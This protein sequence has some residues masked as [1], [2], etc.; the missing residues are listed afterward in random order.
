MKYRP[1]IYTWRGFLLYLVAPLLCK[2]WHSDNMRY[3][4]TQLE[5][6]LVVLIAENIVA[7]EYLLVLRESEQ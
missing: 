1:W 7:Q 6:R 3:L 2:R 4:A 5:D